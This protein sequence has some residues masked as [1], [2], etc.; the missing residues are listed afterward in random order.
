MLLPMRAD[1]R[2]AAVRRE[3]YGL[4]EI[5]DAL[6]V[7]RQLV[8]V[9]RKR[10]SRGIP[11]PD[12]ELA[13]GPLWR[14]ATVEPWIDAMRHNLASSGDPR[15][16]SGEMARR[17]ARRILRLCVALL[18]EKPRQRVLDQALAE[19]RE[20]RAVVSDTAGDELS[21]AVRRLLAAVE[22][23]AGIEQPMELAALRARVVAV[24]PLVPKV[25]ELSG[26]TGPSSAAR[27]R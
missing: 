13:S 5:A 21:T 4:A 10:R 22:T 18:E 23:P 14:G 12:A 8:T 6:G 2:S 1:A 27:T 19:V 3:Y 20:L 25:V 24:L 15:P 9:W 26:A 17:A 16:I 7:E 11:E